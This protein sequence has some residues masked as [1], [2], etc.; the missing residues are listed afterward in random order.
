MFITEAF[1]QGAAPGVGGSSLTSFPIPMVLVFIIMY[2]LILR[3]QQQRMKAHREMIAGL[4]R[5]DVVVTGGGIIGKVVRVSNDEE[6][7]IELADGVRV[8]VVR[9]MIY[10]VRTRTEVREADAKRKAQKEKADN[11]DDVPAKDGDKKD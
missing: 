9:S 6:I 8:R 5:G 10:E 1:A 11:D 7:Q 2:F 4:K 3:P